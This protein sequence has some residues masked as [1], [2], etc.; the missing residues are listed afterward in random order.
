MDY[1]EIEKELFRQIGLL[2]LRDHPNEQKYLDF[3]KA[4]EDAL[5]KFKAIPPQYQQE[6]LGAAAAITITN[7]IGR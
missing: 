7:N 1:Q 4:Y 3:L 2:A 5:N 6:A